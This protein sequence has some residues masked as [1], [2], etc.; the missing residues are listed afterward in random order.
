MAARTH[1]PL[2]NV[3]YVVCNVICS[4]CTPEHACSILGS[5]CIRNC[6]NFYNSEPKVNGSAMSVCGTLPTVYKCSYSHG[7]CLSRFDARVC[8]QEDV[9]RYNIC[10]RILP[11]KPSSIHHTCKADQIECTLLPSRLTKIGMALSHF[12]TCATPCR[13]ALQQ[14][15][16][17]R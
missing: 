3:E 12:I 13:A 2:N 11:T 10:T 4:C 14:L 16:N 7:W 9:V 15:R 17:H 1:L 8:S 6:W 5:P